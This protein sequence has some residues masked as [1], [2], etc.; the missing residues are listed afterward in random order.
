MLPLKH[1]SAIHIEATIPPSPTLTATA[2]MGA[3]HR[4]AGWYAARRFSPS[5]SPAVP[6]APA[7]QG[8]SP[9]PAQPLFSLSVPAR[10]S[11]ALV[12]RADHC[13]R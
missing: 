11:K 6:A 8:G 1:P 2:A 4:D 12:C 5:H 3:R 13:V 10:A 9:P 7:D